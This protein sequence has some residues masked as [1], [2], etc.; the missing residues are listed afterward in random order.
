MV[1]E[2]KLAVMTSNDIVIAFLMFFWS[3]TALKI[4]TV[5]LQR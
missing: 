2:F 5:T 3:I 1:S 4:L